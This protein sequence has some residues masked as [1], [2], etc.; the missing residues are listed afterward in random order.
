MSRIPAFPS[1]K[2]ASPPSVV[3]E[4]APRWVD[5]RRFGMRHPNPGGKTGQAWAR[6]ITR[7]VVR[8]APV[9]S[10]REV[11]GQADRVAGV[12]LRRRRLG[13]VAVDVH[14]RLYK[15]GRTSSWARG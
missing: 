1:M 13:G 10:E 8:L 9:R 6:T 3:Q 2:P 4:R 15:I 11:A 7:H 12:E 5:G 14:D